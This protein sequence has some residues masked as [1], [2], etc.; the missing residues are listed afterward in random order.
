[1]VKLRF[2]AKT[3]CDEISKTKAMTSQKI[4]SNKFLHMIIFIS[5]DTAKSKSPNLLQLHYILK[6]N[7]SV[8]SKRK[9][10]M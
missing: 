6:Y 9:A 5:G 2:V 1:M 4:N 10:N 3:F 8:K 7:N